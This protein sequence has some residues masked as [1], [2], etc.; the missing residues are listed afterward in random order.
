M[1]GSNKDTSAETCVVA[2][3]DGMVGSNWGW[4]R[5]LV[6]MVTASSKLNPSKSALQSRYYDCY[7]HY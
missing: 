6:G 7:P 3:L 5:G 4:G 1:V 2:D